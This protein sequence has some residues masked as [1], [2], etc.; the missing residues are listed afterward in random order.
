MLL[1]LFIF[2]LS[3]GPKIKQFNSSEF[4][5]ASVIYTISLSGLRIFI[6]FVHK[7]PS[8][9]SKGLNSSIPNLFSWTVPLY[10]V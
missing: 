5:I 2:A 6:S 1:L 3:S 8:G 7:T 4:T 10:S 9:I